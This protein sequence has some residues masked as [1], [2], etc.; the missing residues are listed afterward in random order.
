MLRRKKKPE[1]V[2]EPVAEEYA[3]EGYEEVEETPQLPPL[4]PRP[5][6]RPVRQ[7]PAETYAAPT[8]EEI[9]DM[10]EGHA[11]RM[12]ELVMQLRRTP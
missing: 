4:P 3:D 10:M 9:Q 1:P 12:T 8:R 11:L 2:E 5:R 6:A 7:E